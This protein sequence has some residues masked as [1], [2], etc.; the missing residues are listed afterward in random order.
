[1][2]SQGV[3]SCEKTMRKKVWEEWEL[4]CTAGEVSSS[5]K[6]LWNGHCPKAFPLVKLQC[7]A[8]VL[9]PGYRAG[10]GEPALCR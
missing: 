10:E 1:M 8:S 6:E 2:Y 4:Y 7:W 9:P 5:Y 3:D